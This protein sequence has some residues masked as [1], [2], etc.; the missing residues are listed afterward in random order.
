MLKDNTLESKVWT[1]ST[2]C[3]TIFLD[4]GT[5]GDMAIQSSEYHIVPR[6]RK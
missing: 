1:R 2:N 4:I 6:P 5:L 3:L